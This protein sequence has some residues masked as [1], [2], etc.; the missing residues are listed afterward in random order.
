MFHKKTVFI[1][2]AGASKEAGLPTGPEL[3]EKIANFLNYKFD[4]SGLTQGDS[5]FYYAMRNHFKGR[6]AIDN[7]IAA[8]RQISEAV[9]LVNSIDNYIDI[10]RHDPRISILGK[11]AIAYSILDS[12]NRSILRHDPRSST[13]KIDLHT[14]SSTW[15]LH[16]GRALTS[17][18]PLED[19]DNIFNN[20]AIICFNYDR[21]IEH[22]LTLWLSSVYSINEDRSR[23]LVA[24]LNIIRPYGTI[25]D[26]TA[27]PF[28][29]PSV[30]QSIFRYSEN[31]RTYTE[32]NQ[33]V[34]I[35]SAIHSTLSTA[36][37]IIC[38][39]I[40][41]HPQNM[42]MLRS[43]MPWS[44]ERVLASAIGFSA[45]DAQD[46]KAELHKLTYPRQNSQEVKI[47]VSNDCTCAKI[48][49]TFSRTFRSAT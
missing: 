32:Q 22:F 31:I 36:E 6:D 40:A 13:R 12:E 21:C 3:A 49:T 8:A 37:T 2:G 26:L 19:L 1:V 44:V 15:L 20:I 17:N 18:V 7:H 14:F 48:F 23:Q 9:R 35:T 41:F 27:V 30:R 4:I 33:D 46:I 38:L 29:S 11:A 42:R 25:A 39:G 16:F 24:S 43:N 5:D 47:E 28:G 45:N 34:A 10:H